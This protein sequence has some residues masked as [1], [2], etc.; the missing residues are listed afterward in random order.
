M[1]ADALALARPIRT[2]PAPRRASVRA[3]TGQ[4]FTEAQLSFGLGPEFH[5]MPFWASTLFPELVGASSDMSFSQFR[6][7]FHLAL[8]RMVVCRVAAEPDEAGAR[9]GCET[10]AEAKG[11]PVGRP[12]PGKEA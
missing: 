12:L 10:A 2:R 11:Q 5:I 6:R 7:M 9:T 8:F 1:P 3:S 4:I